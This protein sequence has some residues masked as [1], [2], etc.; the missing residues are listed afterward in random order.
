[1]SRDDE[2]YLYIWVNCADVVR[3]F[4]KIRK[5]KSGYGENWSR[6]FDRAPLIVYK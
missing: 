1:V 4:K 5:N 6:T 2:R 3:F